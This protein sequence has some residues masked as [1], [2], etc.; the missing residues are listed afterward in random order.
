M[1]SPD[2]SY[3]A[4][5]VP[6]WTGLPLTKP[7]GAVLRGGGKTIVYASWNGATKVA[8]WRIL[9]GSGAANLNVVQSQNLTGFETAISVPGHYQ[10]FKVQA[11][12]GDGHV[13][14]TSALFR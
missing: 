5:A 4:I 3:R 6:R 2:L 11:L 13:I 14:G 12:D 9:A 1:P 7:S 10:V 8:S